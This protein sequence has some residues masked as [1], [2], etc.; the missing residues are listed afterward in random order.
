MCY[1]LARNHFLTPSRPRPEYQLNTS[2]IYVAIDLETTGLNAERDAITEIGAVKFR[3]DEILGTWSNLVN[4]GQPIPYEIEQ[5]TGISNQDVAQAPPLRALSDSFARFVGSNPIVGH[6]VKFDL[7]F[8]N[9]HGLLRNNLPIDTFEMASILMPHAARYSLGRLADALGIRFTVRHR[10]LDDAQATRQLFLKLLEQADQLNLKIVQEL[11]R[12]ATHSRWP[13]RY[14]FQDLER[15]RA[16]HAFTGSIG[17]QLAAKGAL[18]GR[19]SMDLLFDDKEKAEPLRPREHPTPL[20]VASLTA[21]LEEGGLLAR[22]FPGYE[23]RPQQVKV[24]QAMANALGQRWHMLVEAGTGTGKSLAY[25]LPA[26]YFAVQNDERI[27]ISTNTINLQEQIH[28]KDIPALQEILPLE[29][30]TALM[31]GRSNYLCQRRLD[32]L[33]RKREL[34]EEEMRLLAK[35]LVWLPT[36]M[37]GDRAELF[38]PTYAE[39][40]LWHNVSSE[41]DTCSLERCRYRQQGR[42]FYYH[43]RQK[44]ES[45]HIIIVNHALLLS[46]VAVQNRVLPSYRYLIVDEAHH[47]EAATTRQLSF[48]T[49]RSTL[50]RLLNKFSQRQ[51]GK[52]NG[53]Y[54]AQLLKVIRQTAA[55]TVYVKAKELVQDLRHSIKTTRQHLH[56]FYNELEMLLE[57]HVRGS[58]AYDK[59]LRLTDSLRSLPDWSSVEMI[60]DNLCRSLYNLNKG[61]EKLGSLL[62]ESQDLDTSELEDLAQDLRGLLHGLAEQHT[63]LNAMI[64]EPSEQNIYWAQIAARNKKVSLHAAPLHVGNLVREHLFYTKESVILTSATLRTDGDFGFIKERLGAEDAGELAVGSPF[65]F[66]RQALLY[67]PTDISEPNQPQYQKS[68]ERALI[69]LIRAVRGRTLVLFTSYRQLR[70]TQQAIARPLAGAEISVFAQGGGTSRAQLLENFRSTERSVLLGTRS[71]WEGI[72]VLGPALSC[73]VIARLPFSVPS[74]PV[75][76]ARAETFDDPFYQYSVPETILRFRQGFGRLIRS[77]T[78]R[79]VVVLMDKRVLTK[80]YGAKFLNSLPQCKTV[81]ASLSDLPHTA[82]EWI[83]VAL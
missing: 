64:F 9:Q 41:A 33:R 73:L 55:E 36:T 21:L 82:A 18:E 15:S 83:D 17:Q 6:N 45:A 66:E 5:L 24:L 50:T 75:F 56:D 25:L 69:P 62:Q 27:V 68:L 78:D 48:S 43:A 46:D 42:C 58:Q 37:T 59:R 22:K 7:N 30:R 1:N 80:R 8:L 52:S 65:D 39:Q 63:Q 11:N 16:R 71:F 67:L 47:L 14:V 31:K 76:A 72:D 29:F 70:A 20:N 19:G 38:L 3:G 79:G 77:T 53:D 44:A 40:A 61:L 34:S 60:A 54:L 4:P 26:I 2:R 81:R 74:D 49:D 57:N 10:A 12:I 28:N 32:I 51:K 35:V 23:H 13:L